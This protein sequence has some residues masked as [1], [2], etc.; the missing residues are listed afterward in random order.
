MIEA[1]Q[2]FLALLA[3][4]SGSE[5]AR[6][7]AL[8]AALDRIVIETQGE[9]R[10]IA[11]VQAPASAPYDETWKRIAQAFPGLGMYPTVSHPAGKEPQISMADAV[12]DLVD[13]ERE[14]S[15]V[16]WRWQH[17]GPEDAA[18]Y[19][20]YGYRMQWGYHLHELRLHLYTL[21]QEA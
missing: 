15:L 18:A 4:P 10:E 2:S 13:L 9:A 20:R 21:L 5:S 8:A 7:E 3:A 17:V 12:D 6:V 14:L 11:D 1:V 19:F 16:A